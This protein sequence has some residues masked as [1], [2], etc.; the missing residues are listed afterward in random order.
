MKEM[1]LPTWDGSYACDCNRGAFFAKDGEADDPDWSCGDLR[2]RVK[3]KNLAGVVIYE[4]DP[5]V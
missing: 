4:D 2:Y 1:K 5:I 3:I